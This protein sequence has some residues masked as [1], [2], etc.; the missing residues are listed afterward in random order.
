VFSLLFY[1]ETKMYVV[2]M[3][4]VVMLRAHCDLHV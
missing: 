2:Y 4:V 1:G 3:G